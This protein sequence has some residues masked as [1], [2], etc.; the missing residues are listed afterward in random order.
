M[1]NT[2]IRPT[3]KTLSVATIPIQ[4][5]PRSNCNERVLH[6]PHSDALFGYSIL[7]YI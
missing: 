6:I 3:D 5:E 4:S 2:S 1:S 7:M